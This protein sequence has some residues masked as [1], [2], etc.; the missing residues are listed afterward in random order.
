MTTQ[1]FISADPSKSTKFS[2]FASFNTHSLSADA[3]MSIILK[4]TKFFYIK[5][6]VISIDNTTAM[7]TRKCTIWIAKVLFFSLNRVCHYILDISYPIY[8]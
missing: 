6:P 2:I 1:F 3:L 8:S 7:K 4:K 5:K